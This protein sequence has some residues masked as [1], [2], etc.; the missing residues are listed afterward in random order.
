MSGQRGANKAM[1]EAD[2]LICLGTHLSIPHTTTLYE[3]Y[4]PNSIKIAVNIDCDQ[5][6]NLNVKFDL[7]IRS[8]LRDYLNWFNEQKLLIPTWTSFT[9]FKSENWYEPKKEALPNSNTYVHKL[10]SLAPSEKYLVIDGGGTALYAGFQS[11]IIKKGDRIICSSAIS[12]MGTGLAE[13]IGVSKA[14][15]TKRILC[16]IGDGSFLMNIQD[17]QTISQDKVN[18]VISVINNNGYA[19]IRHTQKE[20]LSGNYFGTHPKW[21]LQMPSIE[22]L[23]AAFEIPYILLKN[24]A[25][26]DSVVGSLLLLDGPVIC[27]VVTNEDQ[28][29]LFKQGYKA[30]EDGTFSPQNLS[31]MYP[32]IES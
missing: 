14:N 2:L 1:F 20:F 4:A 17:L 5:L 12:S 22:K 30:N 31:E 10:T 8:H 21:N 13:V 15:Q 9:K 7:K 26:L 18:V 19:A 27:E 32:F 6:D 28:E 3:D 25:D 23:A 16:F 29:V 11:S 24:S